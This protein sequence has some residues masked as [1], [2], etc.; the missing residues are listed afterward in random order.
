MKWYLLLL[1]YAAPN[2]TS[3]ARFG[4][5]RGPIWLDDVACNGTEHSLNSCIHNGVGIH[6]CAHNEDAGVICYG[7]L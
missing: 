6:N 5:G 1:H 7:K 4:E 3:N 2:T